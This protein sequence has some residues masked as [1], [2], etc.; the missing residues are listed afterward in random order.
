MAIGPKGEVMPDTRI[1][2]VNFVLGNTGKTLV[3]SGSPMK[4]RRA[5]DCASKISLNGWHVWVKH[6][7][8]CAMLYEANKPEA[9]VK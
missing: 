6:V 1:W 5:L 3:A 7:D 9:E 4:R 8:G 2:N